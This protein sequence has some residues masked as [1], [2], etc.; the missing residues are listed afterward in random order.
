MPVL[1]R[2]LD[3]V[4]AAVA[5]AAAQGA[6]AH[7]TLSLIDNATATLA[8]PANTANAAGRNTNLANPQRIEYLNL[9]L[10]NQPNLTITWVHGHGNIGYGAANNLA[11]LASNAPYHLVLNPDVEMDSDCLMQGLLCLQTRP[12]VALLSPVAK[13]PE[14]KPLYLAKRMPS[15]A[16]LFLRGFAPASL[17]DK[18][19][20]WMQKRLADYEYRDVAFDAP[21]DNLVIVS[22][23]FMLL[24]R[25]AVNRLE[26][27]GFDAR[28]FLYFEDFDLSMRLAKIGNVV[29]EP[30]CK[31][32]HAGGGAGK[33][34]IKH[35][36]YFVA[37]GMRF[38][39]QH[40]S[41]RS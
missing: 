9:V 11:L 3:T 34:G 21:L 8:M 22:G 18:L 13:S 40:R 19:P 27:K 39:Y 25:G 35:I 28:Y 1:S 5:Y 31:I 41:S 17:L 7:A 32:I 26:P 33:K 6:L 4:A 15:L 23:A 10:P 36:A 12:D 20:R 16:V 24:R 37:S 30:N 38:F 29:R 2:T 14:G